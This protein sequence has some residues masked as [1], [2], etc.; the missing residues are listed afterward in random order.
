[1]AR[2]ANHKYADLCG[3]AGSRQIASKQCIL[4]VDSGSSHT[5]SEGLLQVSGY[6]GEARHAVSAYVR[7]RA[8][9]C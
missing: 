5:M 9:L 4:D 2:Y 7:G 6:V 3:G 8:A 1:M